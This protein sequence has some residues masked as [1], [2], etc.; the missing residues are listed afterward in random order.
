MSPYL[1][2]VDVAGL[3]VESDSDADYPPAVQ[4]E[5]QHVASVAFLL[6]HLL[7]GAVEH[8]LRKE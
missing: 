6:Q 8:E 2:L 3:F 5:G 4:G 1:V 7:G